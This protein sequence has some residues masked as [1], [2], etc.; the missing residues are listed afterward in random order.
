M[1][2][3]ATCSTQTPCGHRIDGVPE[4]LLL[5]L[6]E[7]P[8]Q[9]SREAKLLLAVKFHELGRLSS[10]MAA[11][12]CGLSRVVFLMELSRFGVSAF[13]GG[14]DELATDVRNA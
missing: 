10:G 2:T 13:G 9:F 4:E 1:L 6:R 7:T 3:R 11:R 12:L 8:E 14:P 5:S